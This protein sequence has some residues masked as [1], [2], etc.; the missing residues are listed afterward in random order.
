MGVPIYACCSDRHQCVCVEWGPSDVCVC[1]C[2][3]IIQLQ[4]PFD[5]CMYVCLSL[6]QLL[7]R[8]RE[9]KTLQETVAK[10]KQQLASSQN[11]QQ[12]MAKVR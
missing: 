10:L 3:S 4:K 11:A 9:V 7:K 8:D 6:L 12:R 1:V 2:L 5:V